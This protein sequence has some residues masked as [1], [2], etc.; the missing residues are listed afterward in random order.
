M[1][2][3]DKKNTNWLLVKIFSPIFIVAALIFVFINKTN[4]CKNLPDDEYL[5]IAQTAISGKQILRKNLVMGQWNP[6]L[7]RTIYK[8]GD[9]SKMKNMGFVEIP[10]MYLTSKSV[11]FSIRVHDDCDIEWISS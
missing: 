1:V 11:V 10:V 6:H 8:K 5:S 2:M 4:N 9:F 7:L 3:V